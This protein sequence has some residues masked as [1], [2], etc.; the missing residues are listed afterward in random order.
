MRPVT[1][2]FLPAG[3]ELKLRVK[4]KWMDLS[5]AMFVLMRA[6]VHNPANAFF[7]LLSESCVPLYPPRAFYLQVI[8]SRRSRVNGAPLLCSRA[9]LADSAPRYLLMLDEIL[10]RRLRRRTKFWPS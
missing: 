4:A 1:V 10:H 3:Y 8:Y 7:T 2:C 9:P 6:A 5:P